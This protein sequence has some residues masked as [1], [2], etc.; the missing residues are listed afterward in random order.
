MSEPK[1]KAFVQAITR[2]GTE[3]GIDPAEAA[4]LFGRVARMIVQHGVDTGQG[5]FDSLAENAVDSFCRGLAVAAP[6]VTVMKTAWD[7]MH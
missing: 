7:G 1:G 6:G 3:L 5:R 2:V 4:F